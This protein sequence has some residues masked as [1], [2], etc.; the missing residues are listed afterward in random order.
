MALRSGEEIKSNLTENE[1]EHGL[2]ILDF[3]EDLL[4]RSNLKKDE[5]DLIAVSNGPGSF[6]GLRVGCSVAQAIAFA[7]DIPLIPLS[8][9]AVLAHQAYSKLEKE[10]IFVVTNAHMKELYIG[11]YQFK[12]EEIKIL[13][14]ECLINQEDLSNYVDINSKETF[15]VGN[16]IRFLQ[17]IE[18]K[19]TYENFFSQASNMFE[20]ID[21][22]IEKK[23][24]VAAEEVS[25]NYLSGEDHWKKAN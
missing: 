21:L 1:N 3:I 19:N 5:L 25:P 24:Y 23:S 6:T 12:K 8:S 9:L 22:A 11:S 18:D 7:N 14:K 13:K 4:S 16:G 15:Y 17:N 20:L 10:K 2:V